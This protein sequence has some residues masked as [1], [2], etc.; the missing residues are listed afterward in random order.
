MDKIKG[1]IPQTSGLVMTF[2]FTLILQETF[3]KKIHDV[4]RVLDIFLRVKSFRDR[5]KRRRRK[6][7]K[8]PEKL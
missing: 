7:A 6:E 3:T 4:M 2:I 8:D 5:E 1:K